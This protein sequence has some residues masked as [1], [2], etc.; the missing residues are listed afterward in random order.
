MAEV[1]IDIKCF[2]MLKDIVCG[3]CSVLSTSKQLQTL[4]KYFIALLMF[5]ISLQSVSGHVWW[6]WYFDRI[7]SP[8]SI[9]TLD[10]YMCKRRRPVCKSAWTI[11]MCYLR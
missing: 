2:T 7:S 4:A 5:P 10:I 9:Q 3:P 6:S 8:F 1:A 11:K